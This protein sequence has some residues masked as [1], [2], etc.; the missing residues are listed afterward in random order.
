M[1]K[2]KF[3]GMGITDHFSDDEAPQKANKKAT[4]KKLEGAQKQGG[5]DQR[6]H[7]KMNV[8]QAIADGFE[9]QGS[10]QRQAPRGRGGDRGRGGRGGN[11]GGGDRRPNTGRGGRRP[12]TAGRGGRDSAVQRLD[13]DGNPVKEENRGAREHR[14]R[15][16]KH[17]GK[18][19]QDGTGRGRRERKEGGRN[20]EKNYRAKGGEGEQPANDAPL[21]AAETPVEETKVAEP[22]V[23][24]ETIGVSLDDVL[25]TQN[26]LQ[27]KEARAAEGIKGAK[28]TQA[29][30]VGTSNVDTLATLDRKAYAVHNVVAGQG[31][32][33][34]GFGGVNIDDDEAP[35]RGGKGGRGGRGGQQNAGARPNRQNAKQALKKTEEDFPTL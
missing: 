22:E 5:S 20:N 14:G 25:G 17:E 35:R 10:D 29:G 24:Y 33:L 21:D 3:A 15:P 2:N 34:M 8:N 1:S 13:A 18:D 28:A 16:N 23:V 26:R 32:D 27:Q 6:Q 30:R 9:I 7:K 4:N 31:A 11:R 12:P 19:R